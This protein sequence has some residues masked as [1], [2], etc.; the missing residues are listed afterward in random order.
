MRTLY[1]VTT[2]RGRPVR[3]HYSWLVVALVGVPILVTFMLPAYLPS[4]GR[5]ARIGLALLVAASYVLVVIVHELGH[6]LAAH[7]LRLRVATLNL[8]PLG[9]ITRLP[10]R[11]RGPVAAFWV[12]A[13]GP[14]FSLALWLA[15]MRIAAYSTPGAWPT[16]M[17]TIVGQLSLYLALVN[18]LPGLPLDGGR[19]VRAVLWWLGGTFESPHRIARIAGQV[20]AYGLIALGVGL[21]V[22]QQSWLRGAALVLLGWAIRAAGGTIWRRALVARLLNQMTAA[23]I[24]RKPA[25][26]IAPERSLREF[27]MLL[28]GR[29]G[30]MS[31]PVIADNIFLGLIDRELLREVP[32][33]RWDTRT[34]AETMIPAADLGAISSTMPVSMVLPRVTGDN[35]PSWWLLPVVDKGRLVGLIDGDEL[36]EVLDLDDEFGLFGHTVVVATPAE[37]ERPAPAA[38]AP[39]AGIEP[40]EHMIGR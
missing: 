35:I 40:R 26:V 1:F 29:M 23:D 37:F 20:V 17:L 28:R 16:V 15:L 31:T 13:A 32:Q 11:Q 4:L 2:I 24:L 8:Y 38:A 33:G 10:D 9:A 27:A 19:M 12:S 21:I 22:G 3:L 5:F 36:R 14:A 25:R 34:V 30:R 7:L 6:L 18:L 39:P